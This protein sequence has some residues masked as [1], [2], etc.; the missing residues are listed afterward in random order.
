MKYKID[1]SILSFLKDYRVI[2]IIVLIILFNLYSSKMEGFM[3][4]LSELVNSHGS[5]K[6]GFAAFSGSKEQEQNRDAEHVNPMYKDGNPANP[7]PEYRNQP[8]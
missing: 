6:A 8:V 5:K 4:G 3:S 7:Y 2:A 1:M